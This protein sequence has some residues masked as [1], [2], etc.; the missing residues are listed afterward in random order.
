MQ[1]Y[2]SIEMIVGSMFSGKTEELL[3]RIRLAKIARKSVLVFKPKIDDRYHATNVTSHDANSTESIAV[4]QSLEILGYI[5]PTVQVVGID[6]TQFFDRALIEVVESLADSGIRVILG[7][8][9]TDW[10]GQPFGIVPHL[11]AIAESVSK[12][13]AICMVCGDPAHRTQRIGGSDHQIEVGETDKY[14]AR[15]RRHFIPKIDVPYSEKIKESREHEVAKNHP[16][17][18][19]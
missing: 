3:R 15:C 17:I 14:E 13:T 19:L 10:K 16:Q 18:E 6:E 1:R 11:M 9:D 5:N 12:Q 7:G 4:S 8:L 2:G